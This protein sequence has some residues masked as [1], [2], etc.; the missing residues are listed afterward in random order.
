[1]AGLSLKRLVALALL[2]L[3]QGRVFHASPI[4]GSD[5]NTGLTAYEPLEALCACIGALEH[6]G[7]ECH[8]HTGTYEVGERTYLQC[9]WSQRH[10]DESDPHNIS[11]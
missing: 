4:N 1:M 11:W 3:T 10:T 9:D 2:V 5:D 8:L 6:A 7:D